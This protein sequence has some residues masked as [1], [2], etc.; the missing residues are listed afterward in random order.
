MK[1]PRDGKEMEMET[2]MEM[3]NNNE[4]GDMVM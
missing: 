4:K 2:R 1:G 3:G